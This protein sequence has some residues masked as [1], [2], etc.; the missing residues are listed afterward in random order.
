MENENAEMMTG[1]L[2][3]LFLAPIA[4]LLNTC[5]N[6]QTHLKIDTRGHVSMSVKP[7][8]AIDSGSE[9]CFSYSSNHCQEEDEVSYGFRAEWQTSCQRFAVLNGDIFDEDRLDELLWNKT[10]LRGR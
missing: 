8:S 6:G 5:K 7:G 1:I 3:T 9:I 2:P 10:R 4:D